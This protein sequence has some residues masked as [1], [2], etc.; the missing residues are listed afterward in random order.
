MRTINLNSSPPLWDYPL[1]HSP[2]PE[3]FSNICVF[4]HQIPVQPILSSAHIHPS[5]L[6]V[7]V[8]ECGRE[9]AWCACGDWRTSS[10]SN[11]CLPPHSRQGFTAD[12]LAH[13]FPGLRPSHCR[14][15]RIVDART[16]PSPAFMWILGTQTRI[17]TLTQQGLLN[18][19]VYRAAPS[20]ADYEL[21]NPLCPSSLSH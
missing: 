9:R 13:E 7:H 15:R 10:D 5:F 17:L 19:N 2:G 20:R 21:L 12:W 11:P 3:T 4:D 16:L 6:C 18:L 14:R 8:Q 1:R